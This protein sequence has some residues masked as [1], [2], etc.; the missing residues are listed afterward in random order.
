[1]RLNSSQRALL[2]EILAHDV[3]KRPELA[4]REARAIGG[5]APGERFDVLSF[6][7]HGARLATA[8]ALWHRGLVGSR[9]GGYFYIKDAGR[10][11]LA[12]GAK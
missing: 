9:D 7:V 3:A 10:A 8:R 5:L 6:Y 11:A 12:G 1:V 4:E 2:A